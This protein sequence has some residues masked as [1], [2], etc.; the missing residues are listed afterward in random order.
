MGK[1]SGIEKAAD[2]DGKRIVVKLGTTGAIYAA[3]HFKEELITTLPEEGTCALEVIHGRADAFIY[4]QHSI[5]R[6]AMTNPKSTRV[7]LDPLSSEPYAMA[8][9]HGDTKWVARINEFLK[10]FRADGRYEALRKKHM[11]DLPNEK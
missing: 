10:A 5:I 8:A 1:D 4:D 9:R 7:V 3:K 6:H 2:A 11:P